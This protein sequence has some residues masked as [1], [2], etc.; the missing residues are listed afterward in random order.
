MEPEDITG[1]AS[2]LKIHM[3]ILDET[4]NSTKLLNQHL[5]VVCSLYH[6]RQHL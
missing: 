5:Y 6:S 1:M 3:I 2:G 4:T